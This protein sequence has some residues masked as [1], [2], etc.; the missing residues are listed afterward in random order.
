ME[1]KLFAQ[2]MIYKKL[3]DEFSSDLL[4]RKKEAQLLNIVKNNEKR[5]MKLKR[6]NINELR[7]VT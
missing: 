4:K 3:F 1:I 5:V 7:N 2:N 6:S